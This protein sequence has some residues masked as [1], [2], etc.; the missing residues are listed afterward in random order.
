MDKFKCCACDGWQDGRRV[1]STEHNIEG[2]RTL[3]MVTGRKG[4]E[5]L[6]VGK[7]LSANAQQRM[8]RVAVGQPW[9][10][11]LCSP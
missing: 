1:T 4:V 11:T 9:Q 5:Q 10:S 7:K 3:F 6:E 2:L 8:T